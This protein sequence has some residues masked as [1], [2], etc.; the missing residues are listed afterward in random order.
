MKITQS[1]AI[2]LPDLLT[3]LDL[4]AWLKG[5]PP[6]VQIKTNITHQIAD[7]PWESDKFSARLEA[8]WVHD[9]ATGK[10][11]PLK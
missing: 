6:G 10:H 11:E 7:R 2:E 8:H 9:T 4:E 5:L 1:A 3:A